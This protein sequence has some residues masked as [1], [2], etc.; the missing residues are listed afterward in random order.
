M[1]VRHAVKGAGMRSSF[2]ISLAILVAACASPPAVEE[3]AIVQPSAA[4]SEAEAGRAIA[5]QK[6]SACHSVGAT[7]QSA[8][9]AAPAF[10]SLSRKYAGSSL[11]E[12]ITYGIAT[13]HPSMP[14]WMFSVAEASKL[15]AYIRSLPGE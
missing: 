15:L 13:G 12:V 1:A 11:A 14:R 6:C 5:E 2:L 4:S 7:G 9:A 3:A 10:R 8:I